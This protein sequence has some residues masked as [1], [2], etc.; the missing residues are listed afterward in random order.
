MAEAKTAAK[1]NGT[2]ERK[3]KKKE[4]FP[5]MCMSVYGYIVNDDGNND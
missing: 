1:I 5:W 4:A 2:N 3:N